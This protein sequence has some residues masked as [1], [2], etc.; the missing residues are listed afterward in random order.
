MSGLIQHTSIHKE[1]Q[2]EYEY[3]CKCT[4][5]LVDFSKTMTE[6]FVSYSHN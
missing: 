3:K 6:M 1:V 4:L 5:C 2:K